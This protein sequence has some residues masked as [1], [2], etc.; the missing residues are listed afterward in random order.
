MKSVG[1]D[2]RL[3]TANF[4]FIY[5]FI[6]LI[7]ILFVFSK[8]LKFKLELIRSINMWL[9]DNKLKAKIFSRGNVIQRHLIFSN[10]V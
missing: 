7:Y 3:E 5:L 6:L 2:Y 8:P 1:F 4:H 10:M 9:S